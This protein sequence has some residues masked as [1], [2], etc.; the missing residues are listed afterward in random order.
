MRSVF[1]DANFDIRADGQMIK[2]IKKKHVAPGEMQHLSVETS[3]LKG[4]GYKELT[5]GIE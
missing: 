4:K 5:V 1:R 2:A 3:L